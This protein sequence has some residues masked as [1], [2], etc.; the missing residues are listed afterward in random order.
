MT[1]TKVA[2]PV[3]SQVISDPVIRD[4]GDFFHE[5]HGPRV[6][7]EVEEKGKG[8]EK[9][10]KG[11]EESDPA[12]HF[13]FLPVHEEKNRGPQQG[14]EGN[15]G[16]NGESVLAHQPTPSKSAVSG[17]LSAKKVSADG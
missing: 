2:D 5:L 12:D 7:P 6:Q 9:F 13:L 1:E 14:E 15:Q 3:D 8:E 4:P 17:Q 16:K 10:Q 11:H